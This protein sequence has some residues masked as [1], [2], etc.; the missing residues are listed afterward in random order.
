MRIARL[1]WARFRLA[2]VV[3]FRT[4]PYS[5]RPP[6]FREGV[7]VRLVGHEGACG[8]GEA[9]PLPERAQGTVADV[10]RRLRETAP[11]LIGR[12]E[13]ELRAR[14]SGLAMGAGGAA[15]ACA[16]D[17]AALDAA[18]AT[19]G[20]PVA[21]LLRERSDAPAAAAVPVNATIGQ[22]EPAAAAVAAAA[23]RA[24]GYGTV[25]LKV[26]MLPGLDAEVARVA[27]VRD[28]IGPDVRL[29]L[30]ANGAW[31]AAAAIAAVR[32]LEAFD[33]EWLEQPVAADDLH[34]LRAVRRETATA[35]A[36]DESV[37]AVGDVARLLDAGAA[38]VIIIKPMALG[39]LRPAR[40][41]ALLA[42]ARGARVA[43]TTT[44]DSGVG[45]AAALHLAASLPGE[46]PA[47]GL[48]TGSLL[49]RDLLRSPLRV[50][51]GRMAVPLGGG[52]GVALADVPALDWTSVP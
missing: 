7:I 31:D 17:V 10:E 39:G 28:A 3:D 41:A 47:C 37:R 21:T 50:E 2:F 45:T 32:R 12:D 20:V 35:I 18:A 36:A 14:L 4:H 13:T 49:E 29:R 30:D 23:A 44:V 48:A 27:A 15:M 1:S 16:L 40:E 46:L 9:S 38:D 19:A 52:L 5:D 34:G 22:R 24:Q 26:G 11:A 42:T 43:V 25:K 33:L 8:V 51:R 6:A